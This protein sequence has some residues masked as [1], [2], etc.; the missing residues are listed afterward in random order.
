VGAAITENRLSDMS[1]DT[2]DTL[3][4]RGGRE[5]LRS[6][7]SCDTTVFS[8]GLSLCR[9]AVRQ[10]RSDLRVRLAVVDRPQGDLKAEMNEHKGG[11]K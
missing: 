9:N 4:H 6:L 7:P 1:R 5:T 11:T 2:Y 10:G 8:L 3:S